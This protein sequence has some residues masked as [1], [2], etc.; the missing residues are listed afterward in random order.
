MPVF[1]AITL[2]G[3]G[4]LLIFWVLAL[5]RGD[6]LVSPLFFHRYV[7]LRNL[8][9]AV[10]FIGFSTALVM[11]PMVQVVAIGQAVPISRHSCRSLHPSRTGRCPALGRCGH[12]PDRRP[13]H[14]AASNR[15]QCGRRRC[16]DRNRWPCAAGRLYPPR[17]RKRLHPSTRCLGHG[18]RDNR[19][20][21]THIGN[22]RFYTDAMGQHHPAPHRHN[23]RYRG[24]CS[25]HSIGA[26]GSRL[27]RHSLPL[28]PASLWHSPGRLALWRDHRRHDGPRRPDRHLRRSLHTSKRK[29]QHSFA[30]R[31]DRLNSA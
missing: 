16:S 9:E 12:R 26:H 27:R 11:A 3:I 25:N 1:Q 15:H 6:Q 5:A 24:L 19:C 22:N 23:G 20:N 21:D 13:C 28:H 14:A 4:A 10:G 29:T 17:T 18:R 7:M 2:I 8:A 31:Q 30:S